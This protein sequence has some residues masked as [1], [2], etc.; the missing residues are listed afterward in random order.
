MRRARSRVVRRLVRLSDAAHTDVLTSL[1]NDDAPCTRPIDAEEARLAVGGASLA[2]ADV[3]RARLEAGVRSCSL[4]EAAESIA[5]TA[6]KALSVPVAC[7]YLVDK[8]KV[9]TELAAAGATDQQITALRQQLIG[10]PAP[11]SPVWRRAIEVLH[12]G[13]Y[14]LDDTSGAGNVRSGGMSQVLGL[15]CLAAI[16]L[17]SSDGPLGVV[18]CGDPGAPRAWHDNEHALV[19]Q[20][21]MQA[22]IVLDNARL[23]EVERHQATHDPLTGLMNRGGFQ[24][25]LRRELARSQR[26]GDPLTVLLADLDGFKAIND[27]HGHE[28][29]DRALQD[30]ARAWRGG[31]VGTGECVSSSGQINVTTDGGNGGTNRPTSAAITTTGRIQVLATRASATRGARLPVNA[32]AIRR[33]P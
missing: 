20:L 4:L 8:R 6:A 18:V 26:S 24:D 32:V 1:L 7:T 16:P 29:G 13:P 3:D 25:A 27:A 9:I 31:V 2:E 28:A 15:R 21:A 17:L 11:G 12:P 14:F 10:K 22:T 5:R 30:L 33:P 19:A 23:R